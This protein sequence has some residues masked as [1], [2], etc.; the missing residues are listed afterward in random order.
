MVI[1][2]GPDVVKTFQTLFNHMPKEDANN[3]H[4]FLSL[5]KDSHSHVWYKKGINV[6]KGMIRSWMKTMT[7]ISKIQ[8]DITNKC[9]RVTSITRMLAAMVSPSIIDH[10]NL[11]ILARYEL[12]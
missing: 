12:S 4:L 11:K 8:E 9:G 3:C 7:K 1:S 6:S 10:C 2:Q 5:I